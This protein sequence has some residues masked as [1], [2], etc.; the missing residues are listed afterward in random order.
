MLKKAAVVLV[1]NQETL[2]MAKGIGAKNCQISLDMALPESFFPE[3]FRQK[4]PVNGHLKLLW[5]GRFMPRKGLLLVLDV[6]QQLKHLPKITL[7]IVGYGE[8]EEIIA[9]KIKEYA[10][11]DTVK[12]VGKVPYEQV[13][14]FYDMHDVFFFTSLRDSGPAQLLEAQAFGM[15]IVTLNLHG[16]SQVVSDQTGIRCNA[17]S[18]ESAIPELKKAI[19]YLYDNPH[20]V[21]EMSVEAG[22]FARKQTMAEK[23]NNIVASYYPG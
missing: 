7:T 20:I 6:M 16:Q 19:V 8:M 23:I 9:A 14:L 22:K 18:P 12:M 4:K 5:V 15:P 21:S 1:S 17:D 2:A 11:E 10:L 13:R 3:Q